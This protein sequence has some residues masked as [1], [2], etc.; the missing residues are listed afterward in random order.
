MM[1]FGRPTR[2]RWLKNKVRQNSL[3]SELSTRVSRT[4][5][6]GSGRDLTGGWD[7]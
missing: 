1:R 7:Q 2:C 6:A 5:A 3:V 4:A